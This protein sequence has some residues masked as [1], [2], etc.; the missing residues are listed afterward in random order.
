MDFLK[1]IKIIERN[2]KIKEKTK[3]IINDIGDKLTEGEVFIKDKLN[4][5]NDNLTKSCNEQYSKFIVGIIL[6]A[7]EKEIINLNLKEK[8]T[9]KIGLNEEVDINIPGLIE[10]TAPR[11]VDTGKF[12]KSEEYKEL[13]F[14]A[15]Y[16]HFKEEEQ[17]DVC[18]DET[19]NIISI[20]L[21][22]EPSDNEPLDTNEPIE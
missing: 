2:E 12:L 22:V 1:K 4:N 15:I 9:L 13:L 11:N 17:L 14:K 3:S 8:N 18:L 16:L 21:I 20:D 6:G 10:K 7:V 5:A 19:N